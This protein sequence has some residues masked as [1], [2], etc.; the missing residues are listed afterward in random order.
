MPPPTPFVRG[1]RAGVVP[2]LVVLCL[3]CGIT[4][5]GRAENVDVKA[6]DKERVKVFW[7]I[8]DGVVNDL[9]KSASAEDKV[10]IK[11]FLLHVA[12]HEGAMLTKRQQDPTGPG[13]SFSQFE[14]PRAKEAVAYAKQKD[15]LSKLATAS[16]QTADALAKA[17]DD[18]PEA[19]GKPWPDKNLI[20]KELVDSDPFGAYLA[21]IA[22]KK[23]PE[24]IPPDNKAHAEYW[25]KYWKIKFDSDAQ[26]KELIERFEKEAN[27]VDKLIP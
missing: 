16:G 10:K 11:K 18:L 27:E 9:D 22:F 4:P 12:W 8:L 23:I 20:E 13:R 24:A 6:K 26:K 15:W 5:V 21:R 2:A 25:A 17:G 19:A 1:T 7:N 3:F 14:P